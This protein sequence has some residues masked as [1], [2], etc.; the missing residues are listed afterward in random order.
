[1]ID[2][3]DIVYSLNYAVDVGEGWGLKRDGVSSP[4]DVRGEGWRLKRGRVS[5]REEGRSEDTYF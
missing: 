1:M 2:C 5:S 3:T 4:V